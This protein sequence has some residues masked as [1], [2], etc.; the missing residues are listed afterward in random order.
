[1]N[2]RI[3][4]R[5]L[6][7]L[8]VAGFCSA[9]GENVHIWEQVEITLTAENSYVNP[10]K[11]VEVWIRLSGPAFDKKVY[12]FWDGGS[13]FK[14]RIMATT[15]GEWVWITSSNTEDKGLN[16]KSGSFRAIPWTEDEI[17]TNPNRRGLIRTNPKSPHGFIY[18]DGT[19][20][21]FIADTWWAAMTWRYPF[22]GRTKIPDSYVPGEDNWCFEGGVQWMKRL[23]F[24]SI[25]FIASFPNWTDDNYRTRV[26]DDS[27]VVLRQGWPKAPDGQRIKNM[28]DENGNMPF[29]FPGKSNGKTDV[30]ADFDRINP[31]YWQSMDKKMD[32]LWQNGFVPYIET[33]RRDH[34]ASWIAYHNFKESFSRYLGYIR[35]RY[36]T[37]NFIYSLSHNDVPPRGKNT[38]IT[39]DVFEYYHDKYGPMPFGQPVTAMMAESSLKYIGH[40]DTAPFLT[41][42]CSGNWRRDHRLLYYIKEFYEQEPGVPGFNNEPY[43]SWHDVSFGRPDGERVIP[44]SD[45]DNY[46]A[47]SHAYDSFFSGAFAG[48]VFG[49]GSFGGDTKGEP[50]FAVNPKWPKIWQTLQMPNMKQAGYFREFVLSEGIK[51]QSLLLASDDLSSARSSSIKM[52]EWSFMLRSPDK[53]LA[54]L[55]F[56]NKAKRQIISN[57]LPSTKYRAQWYNPRGGK[58]FDIADGFLKS[59][60]NGGIELPRFPTG[61]DVARDDWAAKVK[62]F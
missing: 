6:V 34:Y 38:D 24:N 42:H 36:G 52:D 5:L 60:S 41:C 4:I 54:F 29:C 45:R 61:E 33:V 62:A 10:Y 19:P 20:F 53:K 31:S 56:E 27:G 49:S 11:D 37:C 14:V 47:R 51:Y 16:G 8:C 2:I 30:C 43:Y 57:M 46:F 26:V 18:P 15:P 3:L 32:Y 17:K 40:I 21:F 13:T 44:N 22:E 59:D 7:V 50:I 12:G 58:W 39:V 23:G 25:A 48:H 9:K 35:A 55:Y 1:M 28:N